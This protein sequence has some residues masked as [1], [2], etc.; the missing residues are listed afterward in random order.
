ML[1]QLLGIL[2]FGLAKK[3]L[4]NHTITF[5]EVRTWADFFGQENYVTGFAGAQLP[6]GASQKFAEVTLGEK[7]NQVLVT[8]TAYFNPKGGAV[9]RKEWL[10]TDIDA[11]L[12]REFGHNRR[13]R[14]DL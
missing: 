1:K 4:S 13:I 9:G 7:G 14:M 11:E 10:G 3:A 5:K 2:A 8:A 12:K 6:R